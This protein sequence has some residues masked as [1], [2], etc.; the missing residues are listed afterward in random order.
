MGCCTPI[1][2]LSHRESEFHL[3]DCQ[4][5]IEDV[6]VQWNSF[7]YRWLPRG[8]PSMADMGYKRD[9]LTIRQYP[10][11]LRDTGLCSNTVGNETVES[12]DQ[13]NDILINS[14]F[15]KWRNELTYHQKLLFWF[16][17]QANLLV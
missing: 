7:R 4:R 8:R 3:S 14:A 12:S 9:T 5:A 17:V 6:D 11:F 10:L 13:N 16:A 1:G 2:F 15:E